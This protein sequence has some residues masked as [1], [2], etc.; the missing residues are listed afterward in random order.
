MKIFVFTSKANRLIGG[1]TKDRTGSNL[2]TKL[3][4]WIFKNELFIDVNS[5]L[6]GADPKKI[7]AD[8]EKQGYSI[9]EANIETKEII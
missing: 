5:F 3:G 6:I 1:F 7:I 4:D 8:I 9:Q 2:P